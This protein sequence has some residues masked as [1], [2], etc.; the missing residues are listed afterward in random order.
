LGDISIINPKKEANNP[1]NNKQTLNGKEKRNEN[2][3]ILS[4]IYHRRVVEFRAHTAISSHMTN[5]VV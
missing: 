1:T 2:K 5:H 4:M 3:G